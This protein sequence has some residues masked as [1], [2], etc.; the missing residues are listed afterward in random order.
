M[1]ML[2]NVGA[3]DAREAPV[4]AR[5]LNL[6]LQNGSVSRRKAITITS[7]VIAGWTGRDPVAV[8]KH[9]A[10]LEALGVQSA[11][12][13]ADLLS[14]FLGPPDHRSGDRGDG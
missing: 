6:T 5:T 13:D 2:R 11:D 14:G 4:P 9:I 10:E 12:D 8:E 1:T 3:T 7:T